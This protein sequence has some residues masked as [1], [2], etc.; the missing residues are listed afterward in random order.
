M[1]NWNAAKISRRVPPKPA[2]PARTAGP[3][4]RW[5]N[6]EIKVE[7]WTYPGT[8]MPDGSAIYHDKKGNRKVAEKGK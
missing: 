4:L 8:P 7:R 1:T 5:L 6:Q 3:L 2:P